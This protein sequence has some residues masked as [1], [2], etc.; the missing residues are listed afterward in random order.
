MNT[1]SERIA[2]IAAARVQR[3]NAAKLAM[4]EEMTAKIYYLD[5]I[6]SY[7]DR[8]KD[9]L[10]IANVLVKNG[11]PLGKDDCL[12]SDMIYHKFGLIISGSTR[13]TP[14]KVNI[15]GIGYEGGGVCGESH[16]ANEGGITSFGEYFYDRKSCKEWDEDFTA[17]E[18]RFYK[19]VDS[20]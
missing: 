11:F 1:T 3:D 9:I 7:G 16:I 8:I 2:K 4:E 18:E 13:Y 15:Y 12:A 14:Y 10:T 20:L 17:F 6:K 5:F 19:Y